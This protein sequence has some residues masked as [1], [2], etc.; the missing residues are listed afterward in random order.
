ML[1]GKHISYLRAFVRENQEVWFPSKE[2]DE[3]IFLYP[4]L[5]WRWVY[6]ILAWLVIS[7]I[8][9]YYGEL[10]VPIVPDQGFYREFFM[11]AG[12]IVFQTLVIGHLTKGR[13]IH[14]LGNMMTVSLIGSFILLPI[15]LIAWV[16][17]WVAPWFYVGYFLVV[18]LI[19]IL[20]HKERVKLLGLHW[21]ITASWLVYRVLLLGIIYGLG[22]L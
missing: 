19:I 7:I 2:F 16:T 12:Q 21:V 14:Y 3:N 4:N 22:E 17:G 18:V 6:I 8:L 11:A 9:G 20:L 10:L 5:F 13:L 15:L 1:T